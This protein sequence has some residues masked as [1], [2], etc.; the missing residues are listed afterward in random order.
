[1]RARVTVPKLV[2]RN[3]SPTKVKTVGIGLHCDGRGL[4]LQVRPK[5]DGSFSRSWVFRYRVG[6][7]L[8]SLGLGSLATVSQAEARERARRLRD[9]RLQGI[10]PIEKRRRDR[11][12]SAKRTRS[13]AEAAA[14]FA[15]VNEATWRNARHREQWRRSLARHATILGPMPVRTIDR[16][17]VEAVLRPIWTVIPETASRVRGRIENVLEREKVLGY[18]DDGENPARWHG[19]LDKVFPKVR[20]V[21]AAKTLAGG[22]P[23]HHSALKSSELAAFMGELRVRGTVTARAAEFCILTAARLSEAIGAEWAEVDFRERLWTI[24]A[25]RMKAGLEHRVPLS[26]AA[27]EVLRA[28]F[29][30]RVSEDARWIFAGDVPGHPLSSGAIR[31]LF[32]R[33]KCRGSLHGFRSTFRDWAAEETSYAR[34]IVEAA[35]AHAFGD[36][37]E[38]A[39]KRTDLLERRRAMM[40][41]WAAFAARPAPRDDAKVVRLHEAS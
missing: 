34:E 3:L 7:K 14:D 16:A 40:E 6:G 9:E 22:R 4:Y 29:E 28:Q 36:A 13:F 15:A 31:N 30:L 37:T 12:E 27:V 25:S 10:D 24:P 2:E 17:A 23:A 33:M 32:H 21:K 19:L 11:V 5:R 26:G 8:R 18:R 39:Y 1:M 41:E 35:L 20:R 38:R